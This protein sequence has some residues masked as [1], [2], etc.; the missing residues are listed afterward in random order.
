MQMVLGTGTTEMADEITSITR[1][2]YFITFF[3]VVANDISCCSVSHQI[4]WKGTKCLADL[5]DTEC[6]SK[7]V[8]SL[9]RHET[10]IVPY[11]SS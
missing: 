2:V 6:L 11:D 10:Y 9:Q 3:A 1:N 5:D 7:T 8:L 4:K